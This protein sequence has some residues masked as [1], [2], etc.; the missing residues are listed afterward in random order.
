VTSPAAGELAISAIGTSGGSPR[1]V[2]GGAS[3]TWSPDGT[4]IA[5]VK[6]GDIWLVSSDGTN[7]TNL[8]ASS[9]VD[10]YPTFITP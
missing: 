1:L 3:P 2:A 4:K 8:T 6:G 9:A 5:F 10:S 7:P